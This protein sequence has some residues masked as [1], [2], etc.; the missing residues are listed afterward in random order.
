MKEIVTDGEH[1]NENLEIKNIQMKIDASASL[2]TVVYA[3]DIRVTDVLSDA[4]ATTY[5]LPII[6]TCLLIKVATVSESVLFSNK[7]RS[8]PRNGLLNN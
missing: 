8:F 6:L 3:T 2:V 1:Q 7:I 5:L 4:N